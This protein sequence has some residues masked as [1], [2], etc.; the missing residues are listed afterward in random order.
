MADKAELDAA[1]EK[2]S[3][4][5]ADQWRSQRMKDHF[6]STNFWR[7][8]LDYLVAMRAVR[9]A[10]SSNEKQ[11]PI[12]FLMLTL[13]PLI[14]EL[15]AGRIP[16]NVLPLLERGAPSLRP[17]ERRARVLAQAYVNFAKEGL[18]NDPTPRQT[19]EEK[20]GVKPSTVRAWL[21]TSLDGYPFLLSNRNSLKA[22]VSSVVGGLNDAARE[23][24]EAGR[25][26]KPLSNRAK[27]LRT[28]PR[29]G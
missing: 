29:R 17:F 21:K 22:R 13:E 2:A 18:I 24:A 19:V 14:E 25:A 16:N 23:Y 27:R 5:F 15:L 4:E 26:H 7:S 8:A 11:H 28:R 9:V 6:D 3:K 20:F 1:L 10:E 12:P